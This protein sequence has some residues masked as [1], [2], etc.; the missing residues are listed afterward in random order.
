VARKNYY[1]IFKLYPPLDQDRLRETYRQLIFE[2]HPDRNPDRPEWAVERTMEIVEGYNILSDPQKREKYEFK[3]RYDIRREAGNYAGAKKAF[4]KMG[5]SREE[6]EA[7]ASFA[8]GAAYFEDPENWGRAQLEWT[9][10]LELVP[11]FVNA[12]YNLGVL[13]ACQGR[14]QD[15]VGFLEAAARKDPADTEVKKTLSAAM[16]YVYGKEK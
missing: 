1:E 6:E 14:F 9:R 10:S 12:Y 7:E 4:W 16:G 3:I 8:R 2:Y 11:G 13:A 15:A 5:K